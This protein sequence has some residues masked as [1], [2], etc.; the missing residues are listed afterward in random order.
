MAALTTELATILETVARPGDFYATGTTAVYAP[1]VEVEGGGVV[2]LPLLPAQAAQ[3]IA[4]A[5]RAPFGRGEE[6][7]VDTT[8]RRVWQIRAER[9]RFAG[10]HW[11][12][13]LGSIVARAAEG[14][15]VSDPVEAQFYKLLVYDEGSFFVGHRDTEKAP[16]MF[17]TLII[18]LPGDYRG[19]EL[20]LQHKDRMVTLDLRAADP[21]EVAY[22][23][24][25][26]DCRHEVHP[27]TAGCRLTL[28]Y[29]LLRRGDEHHALQPPSYAREQARTAT[30]LRH[31]AERWDGRR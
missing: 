27:I 26:A 9:V 12:Q 11:E 3:L 17:A 29:N 21:S 8:V 14:L 22:A 16:G 7:V 25:Y 28:V 19:G 4:V 10:R 13:S 1:G 2:A 5:E 31:W 6:T 30:L 24:F 23:A 15:G 18:V 20:V